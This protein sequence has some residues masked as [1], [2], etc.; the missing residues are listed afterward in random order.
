[1]PRTGVDLMVVEEGLDTGGIFA[2]AEVPIGPDDDLEALRG[3]LVAEGARLLVDHLTAGLGRGTPQVG[4]PTYAE[5]VDAAERELDWSQPAIDV[6][7]RVR[8]GDAWTTVGGR[9]LKVHRT[10]CRPVGD[11][12]TV[13][14]GD[15][16]V[17]LVVVQPEGKRRWPPRHGPSVPGGPPASGC[18]RERPP[19]HRLGPRDGAGAGPR[20]ARPDRPRRGLRQ[21]AP[22]R[23]AGPHRPGPSGSALRHGA[24]LRHHPDAPG[25]RPAW[26]T[27]S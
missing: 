19:G 16:P 2:R 3:R 14:A 25:L 4:E 22:A 24:G 15:G 1:M 10:P 17:E 7:R 11:G 9:R 21:P 26:S 13:P 20:R 18:P 27:G 5:K 23:A 12:P 6:H 8:V